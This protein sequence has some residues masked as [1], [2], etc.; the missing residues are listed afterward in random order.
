MMLALCSTGFFCS[1]FILISVQRHNGAVQLKHLLPEEG[2]YV[3]FRLSVWSGPSKGKQMASAFKRWIVLP[4]WSL[5]PTLV[6]NQIQ[7]GLELGDDNGYHILSRKRD[8]RIIPP[9]PSL[10]PGG[11]KKVKVQRLKSL[12]S[13]QI[14]CQNLP[15]RDIENQGL[16]NNEN[17]DRTGQI[18]TQDGSWEIHPNEGVS[19]KCRNGVDTFP[20]PSL[21]ITVTVFGPGTETAPAEWHCP[22]PSAYYTCSG[23]SQGLCGV[24]ARHPFVRYQRCVLTAMRC[25]GKLKHTLSCI[26]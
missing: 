11:L 2:A 9:P 17:L 16:K 24:Q 13:Y 3:L 23:P 15:L 6:F 4:V 12:T 25:S 10:A 5:L 19:T 1:S 7:I 26:A 18:W 8:D 21:P 20:P 14:K 22:E